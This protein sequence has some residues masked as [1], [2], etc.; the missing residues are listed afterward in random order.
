M[1]KIGPGPLNQKKHLTPLQFIVLGYLLFALLGAVLLS[2]PFALQPGVKIN[3]I[4][5]L[6]T[7]ASAVSVTGLTTVVIRN[8]FSLAGQTILAFLIQF[9]GIGIMSLGTLFFIMRGNQIHLR[10]RLMIRADQNQMTLQGM[11][12]LIL[13][14][15]KVTILFELLGAL[16]L[17]FH[18]ISIYHLPFLKA[19]GIGLFHGI[20]GFTNAGFDLFGNSLQD[21]QQD[22]IVKSVIGALL[23]AGSIGFPVL[24]EVYSNIRSWRK[25]RKLRFSLYTKIT[26]ITFGLLVIAG[27]IFIMLSEY[28]SGLAEMSWSQKIAVAF[29]QSLTARSGG[30]SS[31][32]INVFS[33][34]TLL[35]L[36]LMM[37]IG[38]S[39]SSCGGGIR[40]T[41][42]AVLLLSL[43]AYVKGKTNVKVFQRELYQEDIVK[44]LLVFFLAVMLVVVSVIAL[45]AIENFSSTEILFEVC[46]AFGTTGL[47]MGISGELSDAGKAIILT[48]MLIGRIGLISLLLL[49][50]ARR[51]ED[52]FHYVKEHIIIGQ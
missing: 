36:C 11:V 7:A 19:L 44:S 24:L 41:T 50:Q 39:P 35:F 45:S 40:T 34:S 10:E 38:A 6:F 28:T 47:S 1:D 9:G 13:F 25:Q 22:Y 3:F 23:L 52:S 17:T 48:I 26:T 31:I 37:F 30:F 14:I 27:F 42:F 29:F 20:S 49:F 33:S 46:S 5:A 51:P 16:I 15:F 8:T 32:D 21:F 18:F 43:T 12:N 4:D 2:L